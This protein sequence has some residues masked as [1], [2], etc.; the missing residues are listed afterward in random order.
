MT[1]AA[2]EFTRSGAGLSDMFQKASTVTGQMVQIADVLRAASTHVGE[3]VADY[4]AARGDF[5]TIVATLRDTVANAQRHASMTERAVDKIGQ[6]AEK[7][8]HA[9]DAADEYLTKLNEVLTEAHQRFSTN[10]LKT[11]GDAN[12]TFHQEVTKSTQVIS[13]IVTDFEDV[14]SAV[15]ARRQ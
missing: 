8:R 7:L 6:A 13:Q 15:N 9:Q 10:M 5:E 12:K 11:V 4:R 14:L 3:I 2:E 1:T